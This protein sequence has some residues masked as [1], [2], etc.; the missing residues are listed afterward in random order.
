[1]KVYTIFALITYNDKGKTY[2]DYVNFTYK[3]G[4]GLFLFVWLAL[5]VCVYVCAQ[6]RRRAAQ[7]QSLT[8]AN[9]TRTQ[10]K[11]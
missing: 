7:S 8:A 10:C 4:I 9:F 1:M 6:A 3:A 2:F 11:R 5:S